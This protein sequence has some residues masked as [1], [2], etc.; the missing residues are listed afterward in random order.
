MTHIKVDWNKAPVWANVAI[1]DCGDH[2]VYLDHNIP[3]KAVKLQFSGVGAVHTSMAD[4]NWHRR[5]VVST[6]PVVKDFT[7]AWLNAPLWANLIVESVNSDLVYLDNNISGRSVRGKY[8]V[9]GDVFTSSQDHG[10]DTAEVLSIRPCAVLSERNIFISQAIAIHNNTSPK[11]DV[12]GAMY[13]AGC[14]FPEV[15]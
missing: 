5:N 8:L 1:E 9:R 15:V 7:E 13:D 10:W 14:R 3:N 12:F 2:V 6:R 11:Y 4:H